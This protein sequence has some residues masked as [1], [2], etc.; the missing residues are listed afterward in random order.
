MKN[1][2]KLYLIS[3]A[4]LAFLIVAIS[5]KIYDSQGKHLLPQIFCKPAIYL[6]PPQE[7][8][9]T[10]KIAPK[11]KLMLTIPTYP[12]GG[13]HVAAYP[14]GHIKYQS[15][16]YDYLFYEAAIPDTLIPQQNTGYVVPGSQL[17]D[18]FNRLLPS[19]G[20]IAKEK[21]EF[22][23]YWLKA[24]PHSPYYFISVVPQTTLDGISPLLIS[25]RPDRVIRVI[26]NFRPLDKKIDVAPP[27]LPHVNRTGFVV[28]EWG[29][30]FKQDAKHPFTCFT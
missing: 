15:K 7:T 5:L 20:L 2:R 17:A 28:V 3:S 18:L 10:V 6:Y 1:R 4:V 21:T 24:L 26:L 30:L 27:Q 22:S 11:G 9:V 19:L 14:D 23:S 16:Y 8:Q 12:Q 25:P 29:G 13:W